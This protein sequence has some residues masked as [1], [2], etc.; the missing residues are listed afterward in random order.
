MCCISISLLF[1]LIVAQPS[2]GEERFLKQEV[3]SRFLNGPRTVRIYLPPLYHQEPQ[4]RY[5][6][7]YLHDGQNVFSSAGTNCA[8]GWGSWELDKTADELAR[9]GKLREI[10][11]VAAD[12]SWGRR[13]EYGGGHQA[14]KAATNTAFENY[15]A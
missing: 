9:A 6:V 5:P 15:T 14:A 1:L 10:I 11:M 3:R 8:F 4:R 7:L 12:N 13:E 2:R